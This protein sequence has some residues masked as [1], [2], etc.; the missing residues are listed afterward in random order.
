MLTQNKTNL[1]IR[2]RIILRNVSV[3]KSWIKSSTELLCMLNF[4]LHRHDEER[5]VPASI[6][7]DELFYI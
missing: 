7:L 3:T 5:T 1:R 6:G 2:A 4:V